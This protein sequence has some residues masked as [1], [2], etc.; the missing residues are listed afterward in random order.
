M[1]FS[2]YGRACVGCSRTA[3]EAGHPRFEPITYGLDGRCRSSRFV[4]TWWWR[5]KR[6]GGR[7]RTCD[8]RVMSPTSYRTAPPRIITCIILLWVRVC[9]GNRVAS[10]SF[11]PRRQLRS[12]VRFSVRE[13][14]CLTLTEC[15]RYHKCR[16]RGCFR[17]TC[18]CNPTVRGT[19]AV[20]RTGSA[21]GTSHPG[22]E[23]VFLWAGMCAPLAHAVVALPTSAE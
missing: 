19:K 21:L 7:T 12:S 3:T 10:L 8:L 4:R 14:G 2:G 9:Q 6:S 16:K 22:G 11:D 17:I 18:L 5:G 13:R 15:S 1:L 20:S 23:G